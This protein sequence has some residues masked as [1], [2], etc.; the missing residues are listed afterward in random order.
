M[1]IIENQIGDIAYQG[2]GSAYSRRMA[3]AICHVLA[4]GVTGFL[5]WQDRARE[6]RQLQELSDAALKDFG[7][8]RAVA[9]QESEHN[10]RQD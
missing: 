4:K 9:W 1:A 7:A 3:S 2:Q 6:R 10:G 8:N 5:D